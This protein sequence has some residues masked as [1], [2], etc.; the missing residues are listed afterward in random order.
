MSRPYTCSR[1]GCSTPNPSC[2]VCSDM[3]EKETDWFDAAREAREREEQEM[4]G[5]VEQ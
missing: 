3:E 5:E 2:P 4:D 1:C